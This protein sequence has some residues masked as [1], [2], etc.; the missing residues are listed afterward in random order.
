MVLLLPNA[1]QS[2][3]VSTAHFRV[4][5]ILVGGLGHHGRLHLMLVVILLVLYLL[6]DETT[7]LFRRE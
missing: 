6:R 2:I 3:H 4:H 5:V 7:V 1:H